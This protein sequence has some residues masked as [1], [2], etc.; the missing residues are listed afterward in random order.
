MTEERDNDLF[1]DDELESD[2]SD[3]TEGG[4]PAPKPTVETPKERKRFQDATSAYQ[5]EQARAN[6]LEAELTEL[7]GEKEPVSEERVV[8]PEMLE[9]WREAAWE[10]YPQFKDY[11]IEIDSIPGGSRA[12]IRAAAADLVAFVEKVET[13]AKN[14]VLAEYGLSSAGL[15]GGSVKSPEFSSMSDEEFLKLIDKR[16]G[17]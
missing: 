6:K 15:G 13:K 1:E 9:D 16:R 12:E 7:R 17:W 5:K 10:R 8:D 4:T 14:A 3:T 2:A 11:G